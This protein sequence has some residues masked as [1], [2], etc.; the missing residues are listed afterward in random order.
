MV[1]TTGCVFFAVY[2][3]FASEAAFPLQFLQQKKKLKLGL[4]GVSIEECLGYEL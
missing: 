2:A 1:E 4:V 3:G